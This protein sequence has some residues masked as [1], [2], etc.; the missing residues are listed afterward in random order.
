M[1]SMAMSLFIPIPQSD[2]HGNA[3]QSVQTAQVHTHAFFAPKK[4]P[5]CIYHTI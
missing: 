5:R 4:P 3:L 1:V 2:Q